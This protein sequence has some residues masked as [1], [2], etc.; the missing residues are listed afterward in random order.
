MVL[1]DLNSLYYIEQ[2]IQIYEDKIAELRERAASLSPNYSGMPRG[3]SPGNKVENAAVAIVSYIEMLDKA[4]AEREWQSKRI[5]EYILSVPDP[6]TRV[7]MILRFIERKSWGEI[8]R[9]IGGNNTASAVRMRV[10]RYIDSN[11]GG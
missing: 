1:K 4:K 10:M 5:Q 3:N 6:Q 7:I 11:K 8:A 2:E 9:R